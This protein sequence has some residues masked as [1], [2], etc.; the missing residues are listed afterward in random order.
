ML[1]DCFPVTILVRDTGC[2][3]AEDEMP[4]IFVRFYQVDPDATGQVP[5]FGLG[6]FCAREI[7]RQHGGSI[8]LSS[9]PGQGTTVTINLNCLEG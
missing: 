3:I 7:I 2:G 6:L 9:Q 8:E 4:K 1:S 5:G